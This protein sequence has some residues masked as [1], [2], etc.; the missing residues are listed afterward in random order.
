ME[1]TVLIVS[2]IQWPFTNVTAL[3]NLIS[4]TKDLAPDVLVNVGDDIDAPEVSQWH[5][6]RA[7]EYAGTLQAS[8]D[9]IA[10]VHAR[11]RRAIGDR[12]YHLSRSNHGER[13][14]KYM[15]QYAP[16][17]SG[18][19][20]MDLEELAGY[21]AA[22]I[23][24]HKQPFEIAPGWV[25]AHGDEG[26]VSQIAGRTASLLAQKWGVSVACGHTHR[27]G[28]IPS[29]TGFGGSVDKTLWGFEVGHLMNLKQAPWLKG[30]HANWQS[31]FG[32]LRVRGDVV[33]PELI[34]IQ[35]DGSFCV[36]GKWY[37]VPSTAAAVQIYDGWE[38]AA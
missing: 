25:C 14:R 2:D 32:I 19:R 37:G 34:P 4:F 33:Q 9:G 12:P 15:S 1:K 35:A 27:A 29:S 17:A 18:L 30:G 21:K 13:L 36:D 23:V 28:L 6:G 38:L 24:Y 10:D 26:S 5:K 31:A 3:D 8:L 11:F 7:G 16:A 22:G 20:A